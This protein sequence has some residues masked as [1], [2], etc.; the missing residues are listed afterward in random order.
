VAA[1]ANAPVTAAVAIAITD[2]VRFRAVYTFKNVLTKPVTE[3]MRVGLVSVSAFNLVEVK[4]HYRKIW[5]VGQM[6]FD[7]HLHQSQPQPAVPRAHDATARPRRGGFS[8]ASDIISLSRLRPFNPSTSAV[9]CSVENVPGKTKNPAR[10]SQVQLDAIR[11][12]SMGIFS[13][14]SSIST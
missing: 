11:L 12:C 3:W 13:V 4:A 5:R 8:I 6:R 1:T 14:S 9:S 10:R 2:Q 7:R